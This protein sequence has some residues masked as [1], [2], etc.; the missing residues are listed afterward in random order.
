VGTLIVIA[1][2]KA[3]TGGLRVERD[4]EIQGLDN[5]LHGERGFEIACIKNLIFGETSIALSA[6]NNRRLKN[7]ED[8]GHRQTLSNW[9][10]SKRPSTRS[11]SRG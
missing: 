10:M 6:I 4:E 9:T 5:A 3:V 7:E 8:R 2:T 1:V 11:A